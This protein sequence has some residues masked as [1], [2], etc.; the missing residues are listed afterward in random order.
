MFV[1]PSGIGNFKPSKQTGFGDDNVDNNNDLN[2]TNHTTTLFVL[3]SG[4]NNQTIDAAFVDVPLRDISI[5]DVSVNEGAGNATVKI[6]IDQVSTHPVTVEYNTSDKAAKKG[7]DY[8]SVSDT[9]V[10]PVGQTCASLMIPILEDQIDEPNED[11]YVNLSNPDNGKITDNFGIVT[12][13]D[14]DDAPQLSI[15]D[16]TVSE[17]TNKATAQI[18]IDKVSGQS[19]SVSY[20]TKDVSAESGKDY[21]AA[22]GTANIAVGQMCTSIEITIKEDEL[23]E[24]NETFQINLTSPQNATISDA[25]GIVTI[26]DNDASKVPNLSIRDTTVNENGGKATLQI[27]ID[28]V[29]GQDVVA[30]YS[31]ADVTAKAGTDYTTS[32]GTVTIAAGQSC[33]S[34][35]IT[36]TEDDLHEATETFQVNLSNVQNA[37]LSDGQGVVSIED[38]DE[39]NK[40]NLSI[41]DTTINESIGK[42]S[43]RVCLDKISGQEVKVSYSTSDVNAEAGKDY[44]STNGTLTIAE[45]ASCANI[46][47][48]ITEDDLNESNET[49]QVDLVNAQNATLTD[50]QG[51]ITIVDNDDTQKPSLS[52]KDVSVKE[53]GGKASVQICLDKVSGQSVSVDYATTD[54]TTQSGKD[55]TGVSGTATITAGQSCTTVEITIKEDELD[56]TNETFEVNLSNAQNANIADGKGIVTIED[57]DET[58]KPNI[59]IKDISV[60]ESGGKAEVQICLDKLSGQSVSVSYAT[61][62]VTAE[63]GKDYSASNGTATIAAGQICT[64]VAVSITEDELNETNETFEVNLSNAQNGTIT[65][66]KGIITIE[67]NDEVKKPNVNIKDVTVQEDAGKALAQVCIDKVSG[68]DIIINY[69]TKDVTAEVGSDYNSINNKVTIA[70][71]QTCTNIEITIIEDELNETSE[72]FEI[73]ISSVQNATI[74]DGKGIVTIEDNDETKKPNIGI[75]DVSVKEDAGKATVQICLDDVSG[76]TVSVSYNTADDVAESVKDYSSANGTATI[77]AGE[78]CVSVEIPIQEDELDEADE[79][80]HVNLSNAINSTIT[81]AQGIVTIEDNDDAKKPNV[82][83]KDLTVSEG[84]DKAGVQICLDKVTGQAVTVNYTSKALTASLGKDYSLT[85]GTVTIAAG[86]SCTSLEVLIKDD[87]L[88]E[89]NETFEINLTSAQHAIITD[90]KGIVTIEDNDEAKKPNINVGNIKIREDIGKVTVKICLDKLSG[91]TVSV[92]YASKNRTAESGKDYTAA[93]GTA[94]IAEGKVCANVDI[95]IA[96]DDL[97]ELEETF[98]INLSNAQNGTISDGQGIVT[99]EDND[100]AKKPNLTIKDVS[101]AESIG[102][103]IVQICLDNASGQAITVDYATK[104]ASAESGKDYTAATGTVTI[105]AGQTCKNVEIAITDDELHEAKETFQ[106][107]LSNIKNAN[108]TDGQAIVTITDNDEAQKPN[109]SIKDITVSEGTGTAEVQICLDKASGQAVI[110]DFT[111]ANGTAEAGKDYVAANGIGNIFAGDICAKIE[112][113]INEDNLHEADETFEINLGSAQNATLTNNKGIVT[114]IDNDEVNKPNL[115][116]QDITVAENVGQATLKICLDKVSGQAVT[117]NYAT[118]NGT[119]ESGK[120]Y[121]TANGTATIAAGQSCA[122]I[123]ITITDDELSETNETIEFNLSNASNA[124]I[125]DNQGIITI[126][127]NDSSNQPSVSVKDL[128]VAESVGKAKV[129]ICLDKASGQ[130]VSVTYTTK[131]A[132]AET[133]KDYSAASGTA[134]IATGQTCTEV[135]ISIT[136]DQIDEESETFEVNLSNPTNA[137]IGDAQGIITI[138]DNDANNKPNLSVKNISVAESAGKA[139]VKVCLDKVSG[140]TITAS[141]TTANGTANTGTDYSATSGSVSIAAGQTCTEIEV[142]I[143]DDQLDEPNETFQISL[144]NAQNATATGGAG[145]ITIEDND[146]PPTISI[147]D[148]SI[149]E[150]ADSATI[151][152]CLSQVSGKKVSVDYVTGDGTAKAGTDYTTANG[153]A[154]V[155]IGDMCTEVKVAIL[156][157]SGKEP[158]ETFNVNIS[159]P[160]NGTLSDAQGVVSIID[161]CDGISVDFSVPDR[162]PESEFEPVVFTPATKRGDIQYEWTFGDGT[163]S[164]QQMPSHLYVTVSKFDVSLKITVANGCIMSKSV[165]EFIQPNRNDICEN[166][167]DMDGDGIGDDCDN[168]PR[169]AN[170]NQLDTDGDRTGDACDCDNNLDER[171]KRIDGTIESGTYRASYGILSTGTI[172]ENATVEFRAGEAIILKPGFTVPKNANFAAIIDPCN[173]TTPF[174]TE[175]AEERTQKQAKAPRKTI[176]GIAPNPTQGQ[177]KINFTLAES[178]E[179]DLKIFDSKGVMVKHLLSSRKYATGV[180]EVDLDLY[181]HAYGVYYVSLRKDKEVQTKKIIL[182]K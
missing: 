44:T 96:E 154:S 90:S 134:T 20:A 88:N 31:T 117:V 30:S 57:N 128:T 65:D 1:I 78:V 152:I 36:I 63:S 68:Q 70:T 89:S 158:T 77:A 74:M 148:T 29:S 35:E 97:Y 165:K 8:T 161:L 26:E 172:A 22:N 92:D 86:Q 182:V 10:I 139:K 67:D 142:G 3:E 140:K 33:T 82:S 40:P 130:A 9:L 108:L 66:G 59:N 94:T 95:T 160:V 104:N 163:T 48:D 127:D 141:Y 41:R 180:Y 132:T 146:N 115:S 107:N 53:D 4:E 51:I 118:A 119:A 171:I 147:R 109:L 34:V 159:N 125:S 19:V 123:K 136:D 52:V 61:K 144:S 157:E 93:S 32:S 170:A 85:N 58:K 137:A 150:G 153:T 38:N 80:F 75:N 71:G 113:T 6:C 91:Q 55:Y 114:I 83:I 174:T 54:V 121:T 164:N 25:Q 106:V 112:I 47:I 50:N 100:S 162:T 15:K 5:A 12:I 43:I 155:E 131:G 64:K 2:P 149:S 7:V 133:G 73:N 18:C 13:V 69:G 45:G 99:I 60:S 105:E 39:A 84:V 168:C 177:V 138:T 14:N 72:T 37:N 145:V 101:V 151:K 87:N 16:V 102:K 49:F 28:K 156:K 169:I 176:F 11:F 98:E 111:T 81:D 116:V 181:D 62:D 46:E 23:N 129:Q 178:S 27:C 166:P 103:A 124:A 179:V 76:Q 135:E 24:T 167:A 122:D 175:E 79:T 143:I 173:N 17:S 120:D 21:E 42:A 110:V 56:E 126:T